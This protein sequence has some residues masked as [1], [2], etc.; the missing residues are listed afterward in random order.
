MAII[1][2][3][4]FALTKRLGRYWGGSVNYTFS[5]AKGRASTY[6]SGAGGF[7]DS[8]KLNYLSYDQTHTIN[9]NLTLCTP[10]EP[11]LGLRFGSYKPFANWRSNFSVQYGSGLPYSS[12][13]T[14]KIN[15]KR[16][17]ATFNTDLRLSKTINIAK[18]DLNLFLD[19]F[20]LFNSL[21]V[22][23]LGSTY[24]YET[25]ES[26]AVAAV[27]DETALG[28]SV[29]YNP[30]VYSDRRQYRFGVEVQF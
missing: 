9:A 10:N 12:Y 29:I 4:E 8:R 28:G 16:L 14:G 23:Y 20:N 15:D 19:V 21:N 27:R 22:D 2:G 24:L 11:V 18:T 25:V 26:H 13:G 3:L 1:K 5:V 17:P 6:S 7:T 30:Q